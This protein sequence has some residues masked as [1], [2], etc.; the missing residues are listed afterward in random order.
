[1]KQGWLD[2]TVASTGGVPYVGRSG[3]LLMRD[4]MGGLFT[5]LGFTLGW[6]ILKAGLP[7]ETTGV[8]GD[9]VPSGKSG[10]VRLF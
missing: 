8:T 2:F 10:I 3:L 9:Q 4:R 5:D 6:L 1:M 7:M